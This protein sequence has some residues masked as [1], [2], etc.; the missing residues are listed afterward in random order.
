MINDLLKEKENDIINLKEINDDNSLEEINYEENDDSDELNI[1]RNCKQKKKLKYTEILDNIKSNNKR[2]YVSK[3]EY[4]CNILLM[5]LEVEISN[6]ISTLSLITFC[7]QETNKYQLIYNIARKFEILSDQ[8]D[9]VEPLFFVRV[10]YR[11]AIFLERQNILIYS[12]NYANKCYYASKKCQNINSSKI[13][14]I[15]I[16]CN[17]IVEKLRE[18]LENIIE[19]F[20]EDINGSHDKY[21]DI[22]NLIDLIIEGKNELDNDNNLYLINKIWLMKAKNFLED[23]LLSLEENNEI[24]FFQK[25]FEIGPFVN[26]YL[27]NEIIKNDNNSKSENKDDKIKNNKNCN[28]DITKKNNKKKNKNKKE[29]NENIGC[30]IFPGPIDN[31]YVVDFKDFWNDNI[32]KDENDC[33]K[34]DMKLNE[35]YCL[36]NENDWNILNSVFGSTN[37]IKRKKNNLDLIR[38][39]FILFDKN[40]SRKNNN[41]NLLKVK[42]IQINKNSN[43]KQLKEKIMNI[44]N[45]ILKNNNSKKD[46]SNEGNNI[47]DI[48]NKEIEFYTLNKEKKE[49]LIEICHSF[50][51]DNLKY[52]SLYLDKINVNDEIIINDFL[53]DINENKKILIVE[54]INPGEQNFLE[55]LK[56]RMKD[57]YKCTICNNV[58]NHLNDKYNCSLC[59]FSMFCSKNCA[60]KSKDHMNLDK[61]L[62][63]IFESKFNLSD[64][65]SLKLESLLTGNG[66]NGRVGLSNLGNTCY[67]NSAIQCLSNTEDL[68][69]YFLRGDFAKEINNGNSSGSKGIISRSYYNLINQMWKGT[70]PAI[71][72]S[73]LRSVFIQKE[74]FFYN[75]EQHDA[76]EFL[77]ALLNNLHEDLNRVTNKKYKEL[78][79]KQK[80]ETDE[81]TSKR[82]WDY[83]KSR[84]NSIIV[85]LFQGQ[86]KSTIKCLACKNESVTFDAYM[87]LQLPIPSKKMQNQIKFLLSSGKCIKLSLKLDENTELKDVI[88]KAL[89]YIDQKKYLDY[90]TSVQLKN[91]IFNYNNNEIPKYLLY[92][93]IIVA[94]FKSDLSMTNIYKT[95][96]SNI[97]N[98]IFKELD[99]KNEINDDINKGSIIHNNKNK[100][101]SNN[102]FKPSYFSINNDNNNDNQVNQI[103]M[104]REK[105]MNIY[106]KNKNREIVLIEGN[107]NYNDPNNADIF[108]YPVKEVKNK[109]FV[110]SNSDT[111]KL[112]Y[113]VVVTINKN[114]SL[115][116]LQSLIHQ[117]L[118]SI[119]QIQENNNPNCIFVCFPHFLDNWKSFK[120][121]TKKC[122][123]CEDNYNNNIKYCLLMK[124]FRYN[125]KIEDLINKNGVDRPLILFAGSRLYN[126]KSQL[127]KGL[128]LLSDETKKETDNKNDLT[129][130]D[131]LE[132]FH[133][134]DILDGEEK[135]YC[136]NC[137]DYQKASKKI[138]IYTTPYYLIVQ[139]KRFK[140]RGAL[141][142]SLL[143]S[144][145]ET[146]IDYKEALNLIDFVSGPDKKKSLYLLYGVIIHK[147]LLSGGHYISLCKNHGDWLFYNDMQVGYCSNPINE[148]AYLLFYKRKDDC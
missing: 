82:F 46:K 95:S 4:F 13:Q 112:T 111:L 108:V 99:N 25:A 80:N 107:M 129:I 44:S 100:N 67:L 113:P 58:I 148:D 29:I 50:I 42:Y 143:G 71:S 15:K 61:K 3:S 22:K 16:L 86:Y 133:K 28:K 142:S 17:D 127:Y 10:F 20:K 110:G 57:S 32:N 53:L 96:Y 92:N 70:N 56:I 104:D 14:Q 141:I 5:P 51:F 83:H 79:E 90:F 88:Q 89:L 145:N 118:S 63:T 78:K 72:P 98:N 2:K 6:K 91:N 26:Y 134:E 94:E 48:K 120:M 62:D 106:D 81:Q 139:L 38:L 144:K 93:N 54:V 27:K 19:S 41:I 45:N 135:W 43:V 102:K 36:I 147:N 128:K 9:A 146:F 114:S 60:E 21:I 8:I 7:Y 132:L 115:K 77:L 66:I 69:K 68:T 116:E 55:D 105:L 138:E 121:T 1:N 97:A 59:N 84:E 39:K 37:Q 30:S 130:Y 119:L 64:L 24:Q 33:I 103:P 74:N 73:D 52:D 117:K 101:N 131:A 18:Y 122:P 31:F 34:K 12:L 23:F 76:Q 126:Q 11:A 136:G 109:G 124:K 40:I 65:F 35:D 140:K 123:I 137:K 85:D 75:N 49:L 87:N 47:N 125:A